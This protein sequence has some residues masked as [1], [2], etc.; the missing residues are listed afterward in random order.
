MSVSL[1]LAMIVKNEAQVLGRILSQA[2][3]FCDELI[4]VDTGSTDE[5]V[6]LAKSFGANVFHF[7]WVDDFSAARNFAFSKATGD[8]VLW[9]DADDVI[10]EVNQ[11]ALLALK[12]TGLTYELDGVICSYQIA[13]DGDGQCLI[14]MPRER[15]IRRAAGGSWQ[16]P[17]HETFM[18]P[19]DARWLSRLDIGI[20]HRKPAEYVERSSDRNLLMLARLIE[21]GEA[22]ARNWYYYGKELRQHD[23]LVESIDAFTRHLAMNTNDPAPRYQAMHQIMTACMMLDRDEEAIQWGYQAMA[24]DPGR[25]EAMVELGVIYFRHQRFDQ[26]IPLLQAAL[27]CIQPDAGQILLENYTWRPYHYLSLCY[28]GIGD[29]FKA[30]EAALKA[31]PT[32]PDKAVIRDNIQCFAQKLS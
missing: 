16:F 29:Y 30:I 10:T 21:S 27:H 4:V 2:K 12:A 15:L 26:A 5:T 1:S 13:F 24:V 17:I 14:S 23:R 8:W 9:L 20:E 11:Q 32:I 6:S 22:T 3:V 28:E 7:D 31:Y 19:Q 18:L 25:A